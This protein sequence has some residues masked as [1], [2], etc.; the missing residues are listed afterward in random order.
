MKKII[1]FTIFLSISNNLNSELYNYKDSGFEQLEQIFG[2]SQLSEL[3][4]FNEQYFGI[5]DNWF[6]TNFNLITELNENILPETLNKIFKYYLKSSITEKY[7]EYI[8]KDIEKT[9]SNIEKTEIKSFDYKPILK[10]DI[11]AGDLSIDYASA[12]SEIL[13]VGD[14]HSK[15]N[16]TL[17][18]IIDWLVLNEYLGSNF[19]LKKNCFLIFL[20]DYSDRGFQ[21]LSI[22]A[23]I[24]LLKI[25][26]PENVF[27]IKGNHEILEYLKNIRKDN[28]SL[29][30]EALKLTNYNI[31]N[32]DLI[33]NHIELIYATLP[34]TISIINP[35]NSWFST[36][37][38]LACHGDELSYWNDI[39]PQK[40]FDELNYKEYEKS[41]PSPRGDKY[42]VWNAKYKAKKLK[43]NGYSCLVKA[44][45]HREAKDPKRTT[46]PYAV[47]QKAIYDNISDEY[48]TYSIGAK[49]IGFK[50]FPIIVTIAGSVGEEINYYP[51]IVKVIPDKKSSSKWQT[52]IINGS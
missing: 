27:I 32:A 22:I 39:Y 40:F 37:N 5:Y 18:K 16:E 28:Q 26:N 41:I 12:D 4:K 51:T 45:E 48:S 35:L 10:S 29:M 34:K 14:I 13:L 6:G 25:F 44:H 9:E 38:L 15:Y 2:E 20:G 42:T 3:D 49:N 43:S 46:S 21:G 1:L 52:Q 50:N 11:T 47:S 24:I 30:T 7:Y 19:K 33:L 36:K 17:Q 8:S 23:A 31:K